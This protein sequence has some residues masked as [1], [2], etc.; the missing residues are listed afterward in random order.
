M[1]D[2]FKWNKIKNSFFLFSKLPTKLKKK[3]FTPNIRYC[4]YHPLSLGDNSFVISDTII[5]YFYVILCTAHNHSCSCM[6]STW[7]GAVKR[8]TGRAVLPG[9]HPFLVTSLGTSALLPNP[10]NSW[11]LPIGFTCFILPSYCHPVAG[12]GYWQYQLVIR[13]W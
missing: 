10:E 9:L 7:R 5:V 12:G 4:W 3:V 8:S 2:K 13:I 11:L 6:R 1:L